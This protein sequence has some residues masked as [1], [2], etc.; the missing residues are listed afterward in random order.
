MVEPERETQQYDALYVSPHADDAALSCAGRLMADRDRG[1]RVLA[2][3]MFATD[4]DAPIEAA[5]R[6]AGI[7][8]LSLGL[9]AA[10]RRSPLYETFRSRA[11]ER[12]PEDDALVTRAVEVLREL[13]ARSR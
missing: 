9:P 5:L 3:W 12:L 13:G 4:D 2:V 6:Q 1:A 8:F 11:Q 7:S 10:T